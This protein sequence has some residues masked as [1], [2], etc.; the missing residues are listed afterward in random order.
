MTTGMETLRLMAT[1]VAEERGRLRSECNAVID[2]AIEAD[3]P[4][5]FLR[6]WREDEIPV[7]Q[8]LALT[9]EK[10]LFGHRSGKQQKTHWV[11]FMKP[12]ASCTPSGA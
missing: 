5:A 7:S 10:P 8:I 9:P 2:Y 3:D 12:K 1:A 4:A 11:T 6:T